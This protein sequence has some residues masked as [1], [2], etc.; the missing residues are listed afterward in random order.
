MTAHT[1]AAQLPK[2]HRFYHKPGSDK[3]IVFVHGIHGNPVET[4]T[5]KESNSPFFWPEHLALK[6][7][8]FKKTDAY[9]FGYVSKCGPTLNIREIAQSLETRLNQ[10]FSDHKY[11]SFSFVAHS[12]GEL[13]VREFILSRY[14][15]LITKI[16]IDSVVL[17][18]TPNSGSSLAGYAKFF[19]KNIQVKD[20]QP[21]RENYIDTLNDRWRE[22]FGE[23]ATGEPFLFSAGYE[24]SPTSGVGLI[25]GK[26]SAVNFSHQ[27]HGFIK[28]HTKIAKPVS[29]DDELYIWVKQRLL[30]KPSDIKEIKRSEEEEKRTIEIITQL[31]KN[32]QGT[33]LEK[34]LEF[35]SSGDLDKALELLSE[36]E[37]KEEK[38]V[39]KFAKARFTKAQVYELKLEYKNALKYYEEAVR[40]D[41]DNT[42]YL[43]EAGIMFSKLAN[44]DK[45]IEF[46]EKALKSDLN[47]FGPEHP[48][49]ATRWN[50]LGLAW[51]SKGEYDRA[52]EAYKKALQIFKRAGLTHRMKLV[53]DNLRAIPGD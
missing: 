40:L 14:P 50:K 6:D 41:P 20:L 18:S 34:A 52:R 28:N 7:T 15:H 39:L 10:L 12:M 13:I 48:K 9:S 31:Q 45:A 27:T 11:K 32:L 8:A 1:A 22:R 33:N 5:Y 36:F 53:E 21:G 47:T 35:I 17:L 26:D 23:Q 30:L 29:S 49:V 37:E 38:Q 51:Y 19:C 2:S 3:L 24:L 25:V 46:Y 4:W 44:Y 42:L 43:N 16:T